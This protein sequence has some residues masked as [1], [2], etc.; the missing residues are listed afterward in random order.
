VLSEASEE[1]EPTINHLVLA[2]VQTTRLLQF[3]D[4]DFTGKEFSS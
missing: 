3:F 4:K 1:E 2:Q